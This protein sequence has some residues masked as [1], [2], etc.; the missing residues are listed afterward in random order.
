MIRRMQQVQ[1]CRYTQ[2]SDQ[3]SS[4]SRN[5]CDN[6]N[7]PGESITCAMRGCI[8]RGPRGEAVACRHGADGEQLLV[9]REKTKQA[10][11]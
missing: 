6:D 11:R 5:A 8:C 9:S 10:W 3:A 1:N 4:K 2:E 7:G